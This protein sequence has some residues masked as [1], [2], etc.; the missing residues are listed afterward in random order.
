MGIFPKSSVRLDLIRATIFSLARRPLAV[1]ILA[2]ALL[3]PVL[4]VSTAGGAADL[5]PAAY[6]P[7]VR[8]PVPPPVV[9]QEAR[10][11][12]VTRFDWYSPLQKSTVDTI[13]ADAAR[14]GF[15][16]ILFQVRGTADAYYQPGPEPWA[17]R[18]SGQSLGTP[19]N[20][21]WDP[22]A[23]FVDKA[24]QAGI[25]LHAYINVYPVWNPCN[26]APPHTNPEHF[27]WKLIG[28]HGLTGNKLNG[29][30]WDTNYN[31]SCSGYLRATPAS[32]FGDQQYLAV[33]RYLADNYAIDGLHLDHIRYAGSNT[34]C[35]PV[36]A[37]RSGRTCFTSAPSGYASYQAW[38]R[39]QVNGTVSKFYE[40]ISNEHP[41][42]MLSAAVW[43]TYIDYWGWGYTE[44]YYDYYQDS[45]AWIEDGY[46]DALM[47]MIYSSTDSNPDPNKQNFRLERWQL[48]A[49]DYQNN[50]GGRFIIAG[51]GS[52]HYSSFAGIEQRIAAA[53]QLGTAGHAIFSYS[54]L[55]NQTQDYFALLAAGPYHEP[56]VVPALS[57][58]N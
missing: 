34:S 5:A 43:P 12:W 27:Y 20:P 44:G 31:V 14:A 54:G 7:L 35:D 19:P 48:L 42:L 22:L 32:I 36:S 45:Q 47:P 40:M 52:N 58:R 51:I 46:I 2:L 9:I 30:Q 21:Y 18:V 56:A 39:A 26:E 57:W 6:L 11:L 41:N 53:R 13:V 17:Q 50:S 33:A 28:E 4:V 23:Y 15:N 24:H 38:Q 55:K 16:M 37:A 49:Q 8:K 29:L 3:L 1:F 10:A 25:Q